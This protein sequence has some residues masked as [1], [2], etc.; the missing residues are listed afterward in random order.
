M[1]KNWKYKSSNDPFQII[2][3]YKLIWL[4]DSGRRRPPQQPAVA[5]PMQVAFLCCLDLGVAA[6][7]AN[8][9]PLVVPLSAASSVSSF[10]SPPGRNM[11]LV[12]VFCD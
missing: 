3:I 8:K 9:P 7:K 6:V 1:I 5:I 2:L 4:G 12:N 11:S 10:L